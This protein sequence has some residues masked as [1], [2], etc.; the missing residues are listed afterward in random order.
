MLLLT[1][2]GINDAKISHK[3]TLVFDWAYKMKLLK[4]IESLFSS[5]KVSRKK[6]FKI[7]KKLSAEE[8]RVLILIYDSVNERL[9]VNS[10]VSVPESLLVKKLVICESCP[11]NGEV[12][13]LS[14]MC[15]YILRVHYFR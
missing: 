9:N 5:V 15:D 1:M 7:L 8:K 14:K 12:Y 6:A 10:G 13:T 2:C 3:N 11:E 4:Y